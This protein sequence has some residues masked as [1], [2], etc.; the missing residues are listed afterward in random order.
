MKKAVTGVL[1]LMTACVVGAQEE[2]VAPSRTNVVMG[3]SETSASQVNL[4]PTN[5]GASEPGNFAVAREAGEASALPGAAAPAA[6][7]RYIFGDRDDY[8]WQL[9]LGVEFFRFRSDVID[10]SMVGLNT[11][12]TYYTNSWFAV[13]GSIVT[14]FA[15]M[16]YDREHVKLFGGAGGVRIGGRRARWEPW[17]HALVGG[18]HLQPQTAL[19]SRN[20]LMVQAGGGVDF[21]VYARLSLRAQ[22]DWV[23]TQY[24]HQNQNNFQAVAGI[25]FHF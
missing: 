5:G 21:R 4:F 12:V 15:P 7:P 10:A 23:Y 18:S 25:V 19:G 1:L 20:S 16:I 14:G 3:F 9:G 11:T 2:G 24:F 17:A 6:K 13:E 8:R 22:A